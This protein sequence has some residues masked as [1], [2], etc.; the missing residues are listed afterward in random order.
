MHTIEIKTVYLITNKLNLNKN[1]L[2]ACTSFSNLE[3]S[4]SKSTFNL[5]KNGIVYIM[6]IGGSQTICM[7]IIYY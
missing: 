7:F 2:H 4:L 1:N 5:Y 3:L 6:Y